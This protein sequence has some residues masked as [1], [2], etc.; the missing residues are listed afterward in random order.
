MVY[1]GVNE[2]PVPKGMQKG[3]QLNW[4]LTLLLMNP[5]F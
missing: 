4:V 5:V 3:E 1:S 2:Q